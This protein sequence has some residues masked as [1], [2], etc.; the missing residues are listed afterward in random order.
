M[1][2]GR[3]EMQKKL[4]EAQQQLKEEENTTT[5]G[6]YV[7]I[8]SKSQVSIIVVDELFQH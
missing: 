3:N 5:I 1:D 8:R 6:D 7:C 4:K 2:E